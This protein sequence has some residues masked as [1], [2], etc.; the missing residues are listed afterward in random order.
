MFLPE[1]K[2]DRA[3]LARERSTCRRSSTTT[4][5]IPPVAAGEAFDPSP[6]NLE[7]R[8]ERFAASERH[9]GRAAAEEDARRNGADRVAARHRR[10]RDAAQQQSGVELHRRDARARHG[11]STTG[12]RSPTRSTSSAR[13]SISAAAA[14]RLPSTRRPF[15]ASVPGRAAPRGRSVARAGFRA[16]GVRA[17]EARTARRRSS[18]AAATRRRSHAAPRRAQAIRIRPTMS[19]TRRRSTRRSIAC[20]RLDL[21]AVKAFHAKFYGASHAELA[22]VGD[23]D[24]AAVQA[25]DPRAVRRL[26]EPDA[27]RAR[28]AAASIRRRRR[29][30][31]SRRPTRRTRR[32]S[33]AC[34]CRST[35][36][37]PT[38]R[39]WSSPIGF[40]AATATRGSSSASA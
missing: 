38:T 29:R 40:S 18:R 27:V 31:R 32:C 9:E 35:T 12:R 20:A 13:S 37:R 24:A 28:P 1:A 30:R 5:A 36:R 33:A 21:A 11:A 2:P 14:P 15:A 17:A 10:H 19:A 22:I 25:A 6:A 34:R 16:G 8:T 26:R 4:R 23:F 39:R 7:A 3:P